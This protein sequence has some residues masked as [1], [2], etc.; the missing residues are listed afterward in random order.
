MQEECLGKDSQFDKAPSICLTVPMEAVVFK[1]EQPVVHPKG[2]KIPSL[3]SATQVIR[4]M[5]KKRSKL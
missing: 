3:N 4:I 5:Y 1:A 2:L